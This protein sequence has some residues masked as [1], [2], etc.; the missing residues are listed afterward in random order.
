[1]MIPVFT[2]LKL[3]AASLI[4]DFPSDNIPILRDELL[5]KAWGDLLVQENSF[6]EQGAPSTN[7]YDD[8]KPWADEIYRVMVN[9]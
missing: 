7:G 3:W 5:W 4:I 8:W 1:M 2:T 6:S 9:T